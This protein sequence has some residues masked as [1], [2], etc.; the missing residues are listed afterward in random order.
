MWRCIS[1]YVSVYEL[2]DLCMGRTGVCMHLVAKRTEEVRGLNMGRV[3][4]Y[5]H[6]YIHTVSVQYRRDVCKARV[7]KLYTYVS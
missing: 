4:V 6:T 7:W 1:V 2:V 3:T 5:I